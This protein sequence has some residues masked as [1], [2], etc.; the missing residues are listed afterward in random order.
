MKKIAILTSGGDAQGMNTAIRAVAKTAMFKGWEVYGIRRGYKGMLE[1]D[2][3]KMTPLDVSNIADKGGTIL[4][5]ARLPE[6]KDPKIRA[7]AAE[8]LKKRGIDSLVTIG[9]DGSYHGA[10][11]LNIEHG[12]QTVGLPGTIDNDIAGTDFTIGFY[13]ALNIV[14]DAIS[15]LR[16]T[17]QSHDRTILVEVMGRNCG[18]IALNA[19]IAGGANGVIIPEMPYKIEAI[20][21]IIRKRREEGKNFDVIVVSEG[22]KEGTQEIA[23]QLKERNPKLDVKVTTLGHIQRGGSPTAFDRLLATRLGVA[24]VNLIEKNEADGVMLGIEK[25]LVVTH[26]LQY[27]WENYEKKDQKFYEIAM[28]LSI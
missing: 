12:I 4:K 8:N 18:D 16:D 22:V 20:E 1:D 2:I 10:Y 25:T 7:L 14:I 15:K 23:R 27:A 26:K 17:A 21:E 9:G 13:T 3:Y 28:M 24:A 5:T 6:F 19:C 11:Y